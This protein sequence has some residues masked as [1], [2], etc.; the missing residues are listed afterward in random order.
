MRMAMD[1]GADAGSAAAQ[2]DA[3]V[4]EFRE[5]QEDRDPA[6]LDRAIVLT[7]AALAGT[8]AD[9]PERPGRLLALSS[10]LR[11][12]YAHANRRESLEE[13]V[14]V[15]WEVITLSPPGSSRRAWART[16]YSAVLGELAQAGLTDD[17]VLA[18]TRI[19]RLAPPTTPDAAEPFESWAQT[20][21]RRADENGRPDLRHE[22]VALMR[23]VVAATPES[24]A[25]LPD[26]ETQLAED[27][28]AA[29]DFA[30]PARPELIAESAS[31]ARRAA[32]REA[33]PED[34][35]R[36]TR[37][38]HLA[39]ALNAQYQMTGDSGLLHQAVA[40]CRE[41]VA[42]TSEGD[43]ELHNHL[44]VL[45]QTLQR[46]SEAEYSPALLDEAITTQ[47]TAIQTMP[48]DHTNGPRLLS[49]LSGM[50]MTRAEATGDVTGYEDAVATAR[51]AVAAAPDDHP[52]LFLYLGN[53]G[54][55]LG[56]LAL[57]RDDAA[58]R[59]E[60]LTTLRAAVERTPAGHPMSVSVR[61]NLAQ[62]SHAFAT[63]AGDRAA[64]RDTM[65][66]LQAVARDSVDPINRSRLHEG[67]A[68]AALEA[69]AMTGDL[70]ALTEAVAAGRTALAAYPSSDEVASRRP[71][72]LAFLT[73][74][75]P[76]LY[77]RT[78]DI[79]LLHE[80]IGL[81]TQL[82]DAV[83]PDDPVRP[84]VLVRVAVAQAKL[85]A[86]QDDPELLDQAQHSARTVLTDPTIDA[87]ARSAAIGSALS[88][89]RTVAKAGNSTEPL[90]AV[91]ADLDA[92]LAE[93]PHDAPRA[94]YL[95]SERA[96]CVIDIYR[97]T[98]SPTNLEQLRS[99]CRI[100][101]EAAL[102]QSA[103]PEQLAAGV[104][105]QAAT[106]VAVLDGRDDDLGLLELA[107][108]L[109]R[110]AVAV[111]PPGDR[112]RSDRFAI[113]A[114]LLDAFG[115]HSDDRTLRAEQLTAARNALPEDGADAESRADYHYRVSRALRD[116][117]EVVNDPSLLEEAAAA[118][119]RALN[120]VPDTIRVMHGLS[121]TL[122][123][124]AIHVDPAALAEAED[125]ARR[126]V[127]AAESDDAGRGTLY[128]ALGNVLMARFDLFG[129]HS[130]I[131]S[132][133]EAYRVAVR[134]P[135]TR[136]NIAGFN[137][138]LAEALRRLH[139]LTGD[140]VA[141]AEAVQ[142]ARTAAQVTPV[143]H[144]EYARRMVMSAITVFGLY[145]RTGDL[146]LLN[147]ALE[148]QSQVLERIPEDSPYAGSYWAGFA[149]MAS[150]LFD[151]TEDV[152]TAEAMIAAAER[153]VELTSPDHPSRAVRL[154]NLALVLTRPGLRNVIP[155]AAPSL[156][157]R[158]IEAAM[159]AVASVPADHYWRADLLVGLGNLL[160]PG[161]LALRGKKR[162]FE[163][164]MME[165][166]SI[167]AAAADQPGAPARTR[168]DAY[169]SM[170]ACGMTPE[171]GLEVVDEALEQVAML[172]E[173]SL[174]RMDREHQVAQ[175][176]GGVAVQFAGI[177]V[178]A[179]AFEH[180]VEVLEQTRGVL[181][182]E[183]LQSR[184]VDL[185]RLAESA[186]DLAEA[187][188]SAAERLDTLEHAASTPLTADVVDRVPD[189]RLLA[190]QRRAALDEHSRV[191]AQIRSQPGFAGFLRPGIDDLMVHTA[192]GPVVYVCPGW[193]GGFAL[194]VDE[195]REPRVQAIVLPS[196]RT[197][198]AE[199]KVA[200]LLEATAA[201]VDSNRDPAG[202][203]AAQ[204]QIAAIL[205]WLWDGAVADILNA[206]GWND[207][208]PDGA[209]PRRLWWCPVDLLGML[210]WH[211]AG[212]H[213]D[214][215]GEDTTRRDNPR[216]ALD[217]IVSSYIPTLQS[218]GFARRRT[219][220]F[221]TV[222][223]AAIAVT[224]AEDMPLPGALVE[225]ET[226]AG[227]WP[228]AQLLSEP[229]RAEVE[230]TLRE[231]RIVHF[232]CHGIATAVPADSLLLLADHRDQPL[233]VAYL[234]SLRLAGG[235]AFLSAC[236]TSAS[237]SQLI[238][239]A[240]HLTGAFHLAGYRHVVGTLWPIGEVS[241]RLLAGDF[242]R[243][244]A[245]TVG[246]QPDLAGTAV[247]LHAAS[248]VL[249][250][251][252]PNV[253]SAWAAHVHVGP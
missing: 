76:M 36:P 133:I 72:L 170:I 6:R 230:Q 1:R 106:D 125:L 115:D 145:Q 91:L 140:S 162:K 118:G 233:T 82:L 108:L 178:D 159:A 75:L 148:R 111:T 220:D 152:D 151:R 137:Y 146:E 229:T 86:S 205:H 175:H 34:P 223:V 173:R 56:Y 195:R 127:T 237:S 225:A 47:Q 8:E 71:K 129:D 98:P 19:L 184:S 67:L 78:Q 38:I 222:E 119:R 123:L 150:E 252:F 58:L 114:E 251:R 139:E 65:G 246:E 253:P 7:R 218:L 238:D 207:R 88:V 110:A 70:A 90:I 182:T 18:L 60:A 46:L 172:A 109:A 156:R 227:I 206:L 234:N 73:N 189:Q 228:G 25:R 32:E 155:A 199:A 94:L 116:R 55:A 157:E 247:A 92:I 42:L 194:I 135:L 214:I 144:P 10:L 201:A 245:A 243:R 100:A 4:H 191:L 22:T 31:L 179:G 164:R 52:R 62:F 33:A 169:S 171:A 210:P 121:Q 200:E 231:C 9:D 188:R 53:L 240:V 69:F 219:P 77:N 141:L 95:L 174:S 96:N 192:D 54:G 208:L 87:E 30:G 49:N 242:H 13:T 248:R 166:F 244:L 68:D 216:T 197:D 101:A 149:A 20:L 64:V 183:G 154:S 147:E 185:T 17:L 130:A 134:L 61:S 187:F 236:E 85:G 196:L 74:I 211:A 104:L 48:Q 81:G 221:G 235:L 181:V 16:L 83:A 180:A 120:Q 203:T 23:L 126:A 215:V 143:G 198:L 176:N 213:E 128:N 40:A 204:N 2:F 26:L 93:T 132:A 24:D 190:D 15:L 89:F 167:F 5:Y 249:R 160:L 37:L 99:V 202:R 29:A 59:A 50:L 209:A 153:A 66:E 51:S 124:L 14:D 232:S 43:P 165:V 161:A 79:G 12:E 117:F 131:V 97:L 80:A 44:A 239:E 28:L 27:L 113:L 177:A 84:L 142:I 138:G 168:L 241:S 193:D 102:T 39:N 103:E 3:A 105:A 250:N 45:A 112:E 63:A 11:A 107:V 57:A 41:A 186:P 163:K 136:D 122:V 35:E 158:G 212:H 217:R 21:R 224:D 226:V